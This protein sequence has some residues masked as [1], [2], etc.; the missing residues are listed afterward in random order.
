VEVITVS[1]EIQPGTNIQFIEIP[2]PMGK[3]ATGGGYFLGLETTW[4]VWSD[5]PG[6][7]NP[8]I[9]WIVEVQNTGAAAGTVTGQVI[10]ANPA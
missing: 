10:C 9:R 5:G 8:P 2:C 4:T 1:E 7:A 6:S 3:V